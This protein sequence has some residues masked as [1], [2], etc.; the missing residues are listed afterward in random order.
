MLGQGMLLGI[1][2]FQLH[3]NYRAK[4]FLSE[5][6]RPWILFPKVFYYLPLNISKWGSQTMRRYPGN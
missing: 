1:L 4:Q 3:E 2:R 5:I 6:A